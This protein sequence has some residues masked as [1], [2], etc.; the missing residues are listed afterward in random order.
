MFMFCSAK[1]AVFDQVSEQF[2]RRPSGV[3]LS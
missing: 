1:A 3:H 2:S